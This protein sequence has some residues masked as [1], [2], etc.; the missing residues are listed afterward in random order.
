M[1]PYIKSIAVMTACL[2]SNPLIAAEEG[3]WF[4]R[5]IIGLSNLSDLNASGVGV[6]GANGSTLI[7]LDSGFVAGLGLGYQYN[8]NLAAEIAWEFRSN[9][10]SVILPNG[11]E[12]SDG[13]YASNTFFLNG[14]YYFDSSTQW[15]PYLGAGLAWI[16]EIDIDLEGG[17]RALSYSADGEFGFQLFAGLDYDLSDRLAVAAELRYTSFS[18]LEL[19]PEEGAVGR[20]TGFEYEPT[21]LGLSLRYKF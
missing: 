14:M 10:S 2:V 20:F 21:T 7:N 19:L 15:Q 3:A 12:F 18:D 1:K 5:P 8:D 16:Q 17:G 9:D 13:N 4:A 11:T 6:D